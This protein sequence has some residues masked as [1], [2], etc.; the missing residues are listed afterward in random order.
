MVVV[1][2]A[3]NDHFAAQIIQYGRSFVIVIVILIVIL[4]TALVLLHAIVTAVARKKTRSDRTEAVS[5]SH[6]AS[7]SLLWL[8][9]LV[10]VIRKIVEIDR[11]L[12]LLF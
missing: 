9:L 11:L 12:L 1:V 2:I 4:I 5:T 3:R 10:R 6:I 7:T 8:V